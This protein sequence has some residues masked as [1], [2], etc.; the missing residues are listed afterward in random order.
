MF[1]HL[2]EELVRFEHLCR[3]CRRRHPATAGGAAG[4]AGGVVAQHSPPSAAAAASASTAATSPS[5]VSPVVVEASEK[6][7]QVFMQVRNNRESRQ[8]STPL[9]PL[10]LKFEHD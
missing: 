3:A 6:R 8:F 4:C 7:Y 1:A 2:C 9:L 5:A 10:S